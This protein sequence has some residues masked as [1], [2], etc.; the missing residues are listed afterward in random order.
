MSTPSYIGPD[1]A[2]KIWK[3]S[4]SF[5]SEGSGVTHDPSSAP[6]DEFYSGHHNTKA[7]LG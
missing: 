5:A 4:L 1:S 6:N 2:D 3:L 7:E